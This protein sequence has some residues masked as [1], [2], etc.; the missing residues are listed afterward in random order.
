MIEEDAMGFVAS[1]QIRLHKHWQIS[2]KPDW[3]IQKLV[4]SVFSWVLGGGST[5]IS[6]VCT[7]EIVGTLNYSLNTS[8]ETTSI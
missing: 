8:V 4:I 6:V 1:E 3:N 5:D 7:Q 2:W